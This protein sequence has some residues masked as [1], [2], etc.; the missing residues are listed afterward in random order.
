[1]RHT[2]C[3]TRARRKPFTAII[4]LGVLLIITST[5]VIFLKM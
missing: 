2:P 4:A 5:M 1:V 3:T